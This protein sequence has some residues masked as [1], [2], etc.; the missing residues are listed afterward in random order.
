MSTP[1]IQ[2]GIIRAADATDAEQIAAIYDPIVRDS[3]ISFELEPPTTAE[4]QRRI[5]TVFGSGMPWLVYACEGT[6]FG[7]AYASRHRARPAY[8]WSVDTSVYVAE[9]TRKRGVGTCLY[10]ALLAILSIQRFQNA[11]AGI[12]LPNPA[13]EAL[14]RALGFVQIGTYAR[15]GFKLGEWRDVAWYGRTLGGYDTP[16]LPPIPVSDLIGS[17]LW[18][19]LCRQ[20]AR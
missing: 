20:S 6:V 11:Y 18:E 2:L 14:H 13:S 7:Y 1:I 8:G 16:P 17:E 5:E 15:V 9:T 3:V 12:T 4:I 10:S 19:E